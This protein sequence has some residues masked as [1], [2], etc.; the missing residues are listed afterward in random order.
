MLLTNL[1]WTS[2]RYVW[3]HCELHVL[4]VGGEKVVTTALNFVTENQQEKE[5]AEDWVNLTIVQVYMYMYNR[6]GS[7]TEVLNLFG[8]RDT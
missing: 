1:H 4:Q 2:N 7:A 6:N 5:I 8:T 3:N